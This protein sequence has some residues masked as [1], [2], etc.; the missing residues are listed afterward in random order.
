LLSTIGSPLLY[1]VSSPL[2]F[3]ISSGSQQKMHAGGDGGGG[4]SDAEL[5]CH[6]G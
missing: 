4:I 5:Q 6:F 3:I 1:T 2:L